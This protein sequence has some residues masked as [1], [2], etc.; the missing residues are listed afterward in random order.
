[1]RWEK[2]M[3]CKWK[4]NEINPRSNCIPNNNNTFHISEKLG[5]NLICNSIAVS[6]GYNEE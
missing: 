1:M 5:I 2:F 4:E 3:R 6:S